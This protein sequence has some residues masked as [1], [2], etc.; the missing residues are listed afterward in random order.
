M[1]HQ[2]GMFDQNFVSLISRL[3]ISFQIKFFYR[4]QKQKYTGKL[5]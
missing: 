5:K 3:E 4:N 2:I 1:K